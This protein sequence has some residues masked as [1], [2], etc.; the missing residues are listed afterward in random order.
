M[1]NRGDFNITGGTFNMSNSSI[2]ENAGI[3]NIKDVSIN[4]KDGFSN[5][6]Q[7]TIDNST[8]NLNGSG[9]SSS[10]NSNLIIKNSNITNISSN[11]VVI[12][13]KDSATAEIKS[14]TLNSA[15]NVINNTSRN[16]TVILGEKDG[17]VK[18]NLFLNTESSYPAIYSNGNIYYYDG[19]ITGKT[20]LMGGVNEIEEN[21]Y[22]DISNENEFEILSLKSLEFVAEVTNENYINERCGSLEEAITK[23]NDIPNST[24]KI[25]SDFMLDEENK[26]I[27]DISQNITIDLMVIL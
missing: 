7:A 27:V 26:G 3:L 23:C 10:G 21:V 13:L 25:I 18:N 19:V 14:G 15:A 22:M 24:I 16:S 6:I 11:N 2:G 20:A 12:Y 8:I 5:A 4:C 1:Y 17:E 9:I